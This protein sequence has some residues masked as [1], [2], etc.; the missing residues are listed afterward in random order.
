MCGRPVCFAIQG[1]ALSLAP[2]LVGT[3]IALPHPSALH[4]FSYFSSTPFRPAMGLW[5]HFYRYSY[6]YLRPDLL[7]ES[8]LVYLFGRGSDSVPIE[9]GEEPEDHSYGSRRGINRPWW[10]HRAQ[11][12]AP[13]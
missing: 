6:W 8:L 1:L 3:N 4:F 13:E 10:F 5:L 12:V 11:D 9:V 2:V 7:V